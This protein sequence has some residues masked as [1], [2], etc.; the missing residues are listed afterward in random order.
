MK[1]IH[2]FAGIAVLV[3]VVLIGYTQ[4]IKP[5]LDNRTV[6]TVVSTTITQPELDFE[7]TYPSGEEGYSLIEPPVTTSSGSELKKIYLMMP[8]E[9]Y[10]GYQGKED[11]EDAPPTTSVFVFEDQSEEGDSGRVTLLQNWA[12]SHAGLTAFDQI[13]TEAEVI[14]LDGAKALHYQVEGTYKK[15]VYLVSHQGNVYLFVGQY[16][17]AGDALQTEFTKVVNS[18]LFY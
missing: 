7:F 4:L 3:I 16:K 9:N 11:S 5:K 13:S 1:K 2:L 18:V 14:E 6:T 8:T 15:D 12:N 10:I 17:E